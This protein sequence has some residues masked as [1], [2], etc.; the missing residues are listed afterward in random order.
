[1][2]SPA[3]ILIGSSRLRSREIYLKIADENGDSVATAGDN[4]D[5]DGRRSPS[6]LRPKPGSMQA[7][8][9]GFMYEEQRAEIDDDDDDADELYYKSSTAE[10]TAS[11]LHNPLHA[12]LCL[13]LTLQAAATATAVTLVTAIGHDPSLSPDTSHGDAP[14]PLFLFAQRAASAAILGTALG[15]VCHGP[16]PDVC[17]ARRTSVAYALALSAALLLLALAP[18]RTAAVYAA[19]FVEFVYAVQ[20]P[21]ALVVLAT[22]YRGNTTGLYEGGVFVTSLASRCGSLLGI[23]ASAWLIRRGVPWRVTAGLAAWLAAVASSVAYFFVR[24]AAHAPDEPQNPIDPALLSTWFPDQLCRRKRW[25]V[26]TALRWSMFVA[27]T[28]VWPSVKHIVGSGTFWIVAVAHTGASLVRTS[29]RVLGS[30]FFATTSSLTYERAASLAVWHSVGTVAG[31]LV[32]GQAFA[33]H[34][35]QRARKWMVSRLYVAAIVACY[36]LSVTALPAVHRRAPDGNELLLLVVQITAVFAAGFGIAVQFYHIPSLVGA[37]FGCDK[38][39]FSAY[40]DGVAYGLASLVWRF[41]GRAVAQ[42]D[43]DA[44][45]MGGG[46][47]YGWAAVALMLIL[48]AILMVEFM[49]HYFCRPRHGGTYETII[50]A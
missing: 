19:F 43:G 4:D 21:C 23:P 48:S 38:G 13:S 6:V 39:L 18:S 40:T 26:S 31:L 45:N 22:H 29:E 44:R 11:L 10:S 3:G 33:R 35:D 47:A 49:E 12:A 7:F 46:W 30:F 14:L 36:V 15:K 50:F 32:A 2:A 24:D 34:A 20:W 16:V 42:H 1:M 5:D 28:N 27:R 8:F 17:G 37:T 25:T 41:V 9:F